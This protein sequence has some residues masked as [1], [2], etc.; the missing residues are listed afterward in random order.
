MLI[1]IVCLAR[2]I[3][4]GKKFKLTIYDRENNWTRYANII[5]GF[6]TYAMDERKVVDTI[7]LDWIVDWGIQ[8]AVFS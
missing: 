2:L 8:I 3:L 1:I 5:L 6:L 4:T 7:N